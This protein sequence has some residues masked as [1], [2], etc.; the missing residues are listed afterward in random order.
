MFDAILLAVCLSG[1]TL[2]FVLAPGSERVAMF[3]VEIPEICVWKRAFGISCP[4]CG[5]T[6]SWVYLAHGDWR[7]A[8]SMNVL[9]PIVFLAALFQIPLAALRLWRR[10]RD[11]HGR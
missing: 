3:G 10:R 6:R 4:G 8:L 5:M 7:T 1:V 11:L 9:G 2:A